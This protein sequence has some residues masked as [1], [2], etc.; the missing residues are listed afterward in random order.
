MLVAGLA[1][2]IGAGALA[3]TLGHNTSGT[4][5]QNGAAGSSV[6]KELS[7]SSIQTGEA[8]APYV[9]QV[10]LDRKRPK[11]G[12]GRGD[13]FFFNLSSGPY[14]GVIVSADGLI[15][16]CDTI[17]GDF[18]GVEHGGKNR[19][20]RHIYV[21]LGDGRTFEA[22]VAGRNRGS[23]L[24][25]LKIFANGLPF[26]DMAATRAPKR[27]ETL[28]LVTRSMNGLRH[29]LKSGICSAEQREV[30][31][32]FQLD[33]RVGACDLG[34]LVIGQDGKPVGI[35]SNL[36]SRL[37]GQA[38]GV[39]Y[40]SRLDAIN[41]AYTSLLAGEFTTPPPAPFLG[42]QSAKAF[43]NK[44]GLKVSSV[45]PGSGA[46]IAG[47]VENDLLLEAEEQP[48]NDTDDLIKAIHSKK[49]GETIKLKVRRGED[50][51]PFEVIATLRSRD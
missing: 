46:A 17:L 31:K 24:A 19:F 41:T 29:G 9:T 8:W 16:I 14:S 5:A 32:A 40:A 50:A 39:A 28:S 26:V 27:G 15:L 18:V 20:I 38:S 35:V 36:E 4:T 37:V 45:V 23:D 51:D 1:A 12:D 7:D 43:A 25:M 44:P 47:I 3:I 11:E 10:V 33:A 6:A 34:G 30:G 48:L 42:V 49:V 21:T 22:Q 2:A 13:E